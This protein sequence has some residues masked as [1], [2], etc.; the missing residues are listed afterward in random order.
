MNRTN[1]IFLVAGI[2]GTLIAGIS[3][4]LPTLLKT[5][6]AQ[7]KSPAPSQDTP[8]PGLYVGAVSCASGSCHGNPKAKSPD[9][10]NFAV[11]QNEYFTW[12]KYDKHAK[13][14]N[15]LLEDKSKRIIQNM[16]ELKG[17]KPHETQLCL[18]CH[19]LNAKDA[20]ARP[21]D[22]SQGVSCEAC[23]GPASG[24]LTRHTES[25]KWTHKDSV[26]AGMTDLRN[27]AIRA[28]TCLECHLG[29]PKKN[30][31]HE[32]I[33]A[34]HPDLKFELDNFADQ[35]PRHWVSFADRR[36]KEGREETEGSRAWATGQAVAFKM[37]LSRLAHR[38]SKPTW[39][40]FAEMDC[41][42][43]HHSLQENSWRQATG[44]KAGLG[45][46]KWSP[47]RFVMLRHIVSVFAPDKLRNIEADTN[48]LSAD[49][50]KNSV[51]GSEIAAKATR[52]DK[53]MT[54]IVE[55]IEKDLRK[56][57][58]AAQARKFVDLIVKD[59]PYLSSTD[60]RSAQQA[61]LAV[62]TLVSDITRTSSDATKKEFSKIL[63]SI[64]RDVET[65]ERFDPK[66]FGN[67]MQ[68][69]Q[70]LL[71]RQGGGK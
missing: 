33:A 44:P 32:L 14:Y 19:A 66:V 40:E 51:G 67:H 17:K 38:A 47:A 54:P 11:R 39:P 4:F 43:C 15:V 68:E 65:P 7:P 41:Y 52:L 50:V 24:W 45:L 70:R 49:M 12:V 31:D 56:G 6:A 35:M 10:P 3:G 13:A 23:H 8:R 60:V 2:V 57:I 59:L 46:P 27:P 20:Q 30:V 69:L 25:G 28:Q 55:Q 71:N 21:L 53:S 37:G 26:G 34:G 63:E 48:G 22:M 62:N 36:N 58:D 42:A 9:G 18:D 64:A 1:K 5:H 61:A 29:S 16:V